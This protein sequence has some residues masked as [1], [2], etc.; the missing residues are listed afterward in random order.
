LLQKFGER[1]KDTMKF[2]KKAVTAMLLAAL[3]IVML[4]VSAFAAEDG[5]LWLSVSEENGE[6][7]ALVVANTQVTDGLVVVTYDSEALTY[8][9]LTAMDDCV[10]KFAVNSDESGIVKISWVA[11][12]PYEVD[13]NAFAIFNLQFEGVDE[14][15]TVKLN[16]VAHD[17]AGNVVSV[18]EGVDTAALE[19][20][21]SDAKAVNKDQYT[22]D[23]VADLEK[24]LADA[25]AVLA[26]PLATQDKVDAA[27]KA[28]RD[29]AE[30]LVLL[31]TAALEQA[32]SDAK[33]VNKD[34]YTDESV[35][36]LEK[37]LADA[38]AMLAASQKTQEQVDAAA[39]TLRDAIN[40]LK[41]IE[42]VSPGTGDNGVAL[43]GLLAVLSILGMAVAVFNKR[44]VAA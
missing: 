13:G 16:G 23:S 14:E 43:F 6:T 17:D 2:A 36:A 8:I 5:K 31:D 26:D 25:E 18:G 34:K 11:P 41:V 12:G 3:M 35:A 22:A 24:A 10:A 7:A 33:A 44:R 40:G 15:S 32:I 28:L 21:I 42:T 30:A 20:A 9:G 38:E 29:A 4:P 19:Q 39:K 27:A 37:A 1:K